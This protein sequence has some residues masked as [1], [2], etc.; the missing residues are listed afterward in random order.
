MEN[1]GLDQNTLNKPLEKTKTNKAM[2]VIVALSAVVLILLGYIAYGYYQSSDEAKAPSPTATATADL[3]DQTQTATVD[4]VVDEGVNWIS[5]EKISDQGI[6]QENKSYEGIGSFGKV[7]YYK[8]G[9]NSSGNDIIDAVVTAMGYDI[10][11]FIKKDGQFY[12]VVKNSSDIDELY[13]MSNFQSDNSTYFKSLAPEK[14]I[15]KDETELIFQA[16]G[17]IENSPDEKFSSGKKIDETRWGNLYQED[18]PEIVDSE[19]KV[20]TAR[21]Y[22]KLNDSVK[23]YYEPKASFQLDDGKFKLTWVNQVASDKSYDKMRTS[24]CGFGLATIPVVSNKEL[25]SSKEIAG[26]STSSKLYEIKDVNNELVKYAYEVYKTGRD[27]STVKSIDE[28]KSNA[29]MLLWLDKYNNAIV[30]SN[31]DFL[32]ESECGKP[33]VYLYPKNKMD[34]EVKVGAK[35]TKSD[36]NYGE[37]WKVIADQSG[38]LKFGNNTYDY[39]FWEGFGL[40]Q[41]PQVT[42]GTIVRKEEAAN[43]ITQQLKYIGL[44]DKEIADFNEFWLPKLPNKPY[45]RLTW[46]QNDE[47]DRLAPMSITPKPDSIIRVFLDFGGFD[48]EIVIDSQELT[49]YDRIGFTAVEWGG[50]LTK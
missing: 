38:K 45:I 14:L 11:R 24:G 37:G 2:W 31:R 15:T 7:E 23:A 39:L 40:G 32:P 19:G 6:I 18:G 30:Y 28:F 12:R 50:L 3:I 8:V 48:K 26:T 20:R 41:Y 1:E 46:F 42:K 47:L 29:G 25:I 22:V 17:P 43:K 44:N 27:G 9:T 35:I 16:Y 49:K 21:Y 10:Q 13:T 36:P 33:V 34:V 4:R 5:P